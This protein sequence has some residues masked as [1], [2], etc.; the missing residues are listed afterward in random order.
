MN[1]IAKLLMNSLYG[2]FGMD[3]SLEQTNICNNKEIL[4]L[5]NNSA[6][7]LIGIEPLGSVSYI[8]TQESDN[9][10]ITT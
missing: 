6:N 2:R 7:P 10:S 1:M 5:L 4:N 9:I 3:Y 8:V